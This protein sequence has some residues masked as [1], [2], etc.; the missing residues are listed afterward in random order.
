MK[1]AGPCITTGRPLSK[2]HTI[3]IDT[4]DPGGYGP[5][6]TPNAGRAERILRSDR[7]RAA[8]YRE[9]SCRLEGRGHDDE[10]R[11]LR[12]EHERLRAD[13][14]GMIEAAV[15]AVL[16]QVAAE[17]PEVVDKILTAGRLERNG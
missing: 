2:G 16:D 12:R 17:L 9:A 7:L 4:S 15:E 10:L 8:Q 6:G 14:P 5:F 1:T 13:I 11:K 3:M